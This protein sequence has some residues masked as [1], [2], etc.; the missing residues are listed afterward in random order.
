[1][2][3]GRFT[4]D[5][6]VTL[7]RKSGYKIIFIWDERQ[8]SYGQRNYVSYSSLSRSEAQIYLQTHINKSTS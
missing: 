5:F 6:N 8:K 3:N 2:M 7:A 4:N 1:M